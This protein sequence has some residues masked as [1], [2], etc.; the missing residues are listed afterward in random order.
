MGN[1]KFILETAYPVRSRGHRSP[2][3]TTYNAIRQEKHYHKAWVFF[4][5][6]ILIPYPHG[7]MLYCKICVYISDVAEHIQPE[8]LRNLYC[9]KCSMSFGVLDEEFTYTRYSR[10]EQS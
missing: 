4:V 7:H 10:H 9:I 6:D 3:M 5:L 8:L 1:Q 2:D